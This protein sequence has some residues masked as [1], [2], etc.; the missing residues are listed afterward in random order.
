MS[1][2][3]SANAVSAIL[4]ENT[5]EVFLVIV[6]IT[7]ASLATPL[8]FVNNN[9]D[10]TSSGNVFTAFPFEVNLPQEQ[11]SQEYRAQLRIDNIDRQVSDAIRALPTTPSVNLEVVLASSPD[12]V[13]LSFD[14]S[15]ESVEI[16]DT[17]V[18]AELVDA[19]LT[20]EPYPG[21]VFNP[22]DFPALF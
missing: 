3:L 22:V 10:I 7:H 1:R 13:E 20:R 5:G 19:D 16:S 9:E 6:T 18:T 17:T 14:F 15:V 11:E 2:P 8:R 12:T 21:D 4:A